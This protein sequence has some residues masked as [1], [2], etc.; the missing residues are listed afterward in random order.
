MTAPPVPDV[1]TTTPVRWG[2]LGAA[3]IAT[4]TVIPAMQQSAL[5]PVVALASRTLDKA[6][7]A[8]RALGIPRAYGSY[9]ELLA[10]PEVDAIYNPLPN[11]LHVP[12]SVRAADAG[13]HVLCE[14]PIALTAAQAREL[15]AARDRNGVVVAEAFMVRAHPRWH[16]VRAMVREGMIGDLHLVAGHFSYSRRDPDDVRSR[17]EWGGGVLLDIGCYPIT[18]SRWLFGTEPQDVVASLERDP[19][20]GVDRL[21]GAIL[22]FADGQCSFTCAGQLALHQRMQLIGTRGRIDVEVPFNAPADR[23]SVIRLDDGRDLTGGGLQSFE[24]PAANQYTLQGEHFAR[25]VRGQGDVPVSVDDAIANMAVID[26]LFASAE[27]GRWESPS[28]F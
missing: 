14:K 5:T 23:P 16:R 2:V 26:A 28:R 25:A 12:W 27:S 19:E 11:H 4:G 8:A 13:R 7:A 22:R 15:R 3:G 21:C 18:L 9:D 17:V 6:A 1:P 20:L 24:I 10:D